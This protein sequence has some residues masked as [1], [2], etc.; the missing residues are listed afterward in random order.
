MRAVTGNWPATNAVSI[1][2]L[3]PASGARKC[4]CTFTNFL[5]FLLVFLAGKFSL[6]SVGH[7][8]QQTEPGNEELGKAMAS[9]HTQ[10]PFTP[11]NLKGP[12]SLFFNRAY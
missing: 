1:L 2:P 8:D 12:F 11:F 5:G 6:I 4:V 9:L 3:C 7:T 10:W